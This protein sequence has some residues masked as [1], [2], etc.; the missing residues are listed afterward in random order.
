MS[1]YPCGLEQTACS[2]FPLQN[3]SSSNALICMAH[4]FLY[5]QH[6]QLQH[7][8]THLTCSFSKKTQEDTLQIKS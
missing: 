6:K 1:D 4:T 8:S 5:A 3:R 2:D 7:L